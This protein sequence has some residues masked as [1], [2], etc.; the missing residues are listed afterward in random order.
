MFEKI[1][2]L[3]DIAKNKMKN[4]HDP[5]H[6]LGHVDRVAK[7]SER[8][9]KDHGLNKTQIEALI[10][11]SYWHDVSRT[12]TKKPSIILMPLVDDMLSAIMLWLYSIKLGIFKGNVAGMASRVILCKSLGTGAFFTRLF[13]R[14]K[15]R[16]MIDIL[17]DADMLDVL[18]QDRIKKLMILAE[19]SRLYKLGYKTAVSWFLNNSQLHMRT[20]AARVYLEQMMVNFWEWLKEKTVYKWHIDKFGE[21]WVKK[22]LTLAELLIRHIRRLNSF[23]LKDS[24]I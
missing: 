5:V 8:L 16:I 6:D 7:Y 3:T 1:K 23:A 4:S 18:N 14:P 19:K 11:A 13:M 12:I 24:Q 15:N 20:K 2:K 9:G 17:K 21:K 10:L 22:M